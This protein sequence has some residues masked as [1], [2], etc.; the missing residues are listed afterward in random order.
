MPKKKITKEEIVTPPTTAEPVK[1]EKDTVEISRKEWQDTQNKLR[2][3]VEVADRGRVFNYENQQNAQTKKPLKVKM[4]L[5]GGGIIV[6]WQTLKDELVKHPTTG[7]TVGEQQEYEL[8]IQDDEDK[9]QK[10]RVNGYPTFSNA[11][12][13]EREECEVISK[14][15]S[16]NGEVSYD[17][18]F[19]SGRILRA[20]SARFVN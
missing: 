14:S 11:R 10:V 15:E 17:L 20:I 7:L 9:I 16:Y 5:F 1:P 13:N 18:Q 12:Y 4:S 2:M 8:L 6:G 19:P 3:L